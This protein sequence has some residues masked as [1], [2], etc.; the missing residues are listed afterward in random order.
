MDPRDG[1]LGAPEKEALYHSWC[2]VA[3]C[4]EEDPG[5]DVLEVCASRPT[6]CSCYGYSGLRRG[7]ARSVVVGPG[8]GAEVPLSCVRQSEM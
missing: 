7:L 5:E 2:R 6:L 8:E 1:K 4:V 3:P